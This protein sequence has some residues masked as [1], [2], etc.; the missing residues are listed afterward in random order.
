MNISGIS[1]HTSYI[2]AITATEARYQVAATEVS[3][4]VELAEVGDLFSNLAFCLAQLGK[5]NEAVKALEAGK[6]RGLAEALARDRA[7]L[8][9]V[10][11]EDRA[12]F[13]AVCSRIKSLQVKARAW[14]PMIGSDR[15][16]SQSFPEIS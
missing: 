8:D 16:T 1:A 2:T 14:D 13:E 5:P 15:T 6:A 11:P 9:G 12:A 7:V 3:R 4:Q 10:K